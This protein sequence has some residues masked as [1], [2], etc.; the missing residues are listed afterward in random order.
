MEPRVLAVL[1]RGVIP[2]D[3]P[4]LRADDLGATRGDGVFETAHVRG[5]EAWL[6]DQHLAR[7]RTSADRLHLELPP[8]AELADLAASAVAAWP[9]DREGA[10]KLVCTRGPESDPSPTTYVL[11]VPVRESLVRQRR[12]GVRVS[13]ASLGVTADVRS[14]APWL[15]GGVKSLS[16]AVNMAAL[17]WAESQQV[18]D[19]ILVS[20]DDQVLEAPTASV[21]WLAGSTLY[22]VP[23]D[24]GILPGITA[25]YLLEHASELGFDV[26]RRRVDLDGLLAADGVWL[27]S[28]V[29]GLAQV[30]ELDGKPLSDPGRTTAIR[31]LL[32]F[33]V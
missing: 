14:S 23:D 25:N 21:V 12:D 26:Q 22:T 27:C 24:T 7:M 32:G 19:V 2:F 3:T 33:G 13:S 1:G 18:D 29:R 11:L 10:L 20:T 31:D 8:A 28:S 4:L 30:I 15:L 6:L 16:Y 9:R 5:G 17:R